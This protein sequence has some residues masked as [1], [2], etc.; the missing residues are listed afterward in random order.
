M[1]VVFISRVIPRVLMIYLFLCL[2]R[3]SLT[4]DG[5]TCTLLLHVPCY[6]WNEQAGDIY[7]YIYALWMKNSWRVS[8]PTSISSLVLQLLHFPGLCSPSGRGKMYYFRDL[9]KDIYPNGSGSPCFVENLWPFPML[10]SNKRV[11]H[12]FMMF[13]YFTSCLLSESAIAII[14]T[15]M[16]LMKNTF[17]I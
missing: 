5:V 2:P 6:S 4:S 9:L 11:C 1:L 12:W 15:I 10:H 13:L 14:S 3:A 8:E 17:W 7:I 16:V